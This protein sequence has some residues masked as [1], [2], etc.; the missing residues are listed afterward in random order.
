[1]LFYFGEIYVQLPTH[2]Q[3]KIL[4]SLCFVH[5]SC[6]GTVLCFIL[7]TVK[8]CVLMPIVEAVCSSLVMSLTELQCQVAA[9]MSCFL[10]V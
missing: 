10:L 9:L 8:S 7:H 2:L 1:M 3:K 5:P 4:M 6:T